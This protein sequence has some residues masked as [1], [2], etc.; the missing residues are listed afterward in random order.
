[1]TRVPSGAM[2]DVIRLEASCTNCIDS[3]VEAV[4]PLLLRSRLVPSGRMI[5]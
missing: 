1:M 2:T 4:I 3:P 5:S